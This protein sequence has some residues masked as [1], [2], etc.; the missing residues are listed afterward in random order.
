MV[1]KKR[2]R[3]VASDDEPAEKPVASKKAKATTTQN[4]TKKTTTKPAMKKKITKQKTTTKKITKQ[5][6]PTK[7][8]TKTTS[9]SPSWEELNPDSMNSNTDD[10]EKDR[11]CLRAHLG[12]GPFSSEQLKCWGDSWNNYF[13]EPYLSRE[14]RALRACTACGKK[15][16]P[17]KPKQCRDGEC[18]LQA[19]IF[20]CPR[21]ALAW[22]KC[23]FALCLSCKQEKYAKS[24]QKKRKR[25]ERTVLDF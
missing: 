9:T 14:E 8:T 10:P 16:V 5:K 12:A 23:T 24:P 3:D 21:A 20:V 18:S 6:T 17:K 25:R 11:I 1:F 2:D 19:G 13:R 15:I 22:H 4:V 7:T